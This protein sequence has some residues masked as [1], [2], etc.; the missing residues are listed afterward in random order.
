MSIN[1]IEEFKVWTLISFT[2]S[3]IWCPSAWR[4]TQH[5]VVSWHFPGQVIG[6]VDGVHVDVLMAVLAHRLYHLPPDLV[7]RFLRSTEETHRRKHMTHQ[8]QRIPFAHFHSL[9]LLFTCDLFE[10]NLTGEFVQLTFLHTA[11]RMMKAV[12]MMTS[13]AKTAANTVT[14][15]NSGATGER[16]LSIR[17][18]EAEIFLFKSSQIQIKLHFL[19]IF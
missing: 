11:M 2:G 5:Q 17:Q 3:S 4:L 12:M 15:E 10:R 8:N 9:S 18:D 16:T 7:T 1:L 14:W 6:Q 13:R 19:L